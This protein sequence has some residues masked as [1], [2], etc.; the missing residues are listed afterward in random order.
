M[1][2]TDEIYQ[3]ISDGSGFFQHGHT[4]LAHP[5]ACAAGLAVVTALLERN[6][7]ERCAVQGD[8]LMSALQ[9]QF[10][11]HEFVGDIRGRGLFLGVE[12]V[13]DRD[14]KQPF[15]SALGL[16]KKIKAA[17]FDAGLICYPM[18]GTLDGKSGDHVLLAPAFII[19]D[20]QIAEL[21]E[22]LSVAID[23]SVDELV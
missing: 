22:K 8:K 14:T 2:C 15:D 11:D 16:N 6:L 3:T 12:L 4:Y 7:V 17:A 1:L 18:G 9:E 21:V 13:R 23:S 10:E 5:T 19:E 20:D